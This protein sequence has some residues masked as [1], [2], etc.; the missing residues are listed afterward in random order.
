MKRLALLFWLLASVTTSAQ[1]VIFSEDVITRPTAASRTYM[2]IVGGTPKLIRAGS[3]PIADLTPAYSLTGLRNMSVTPDRVWLN[4]SGK[5]G[6]FVYQP[7]NTTAVDNGGATWVVTSSGKRYRYQPENG[8]ISI[9]RFGADSLGQS[10]SVNAFTA[11]QA[12]GFDVDVPP[13][14]YAMPQSLTLNLSRFSMRGRATLDFTMLSSGTAIHIRGDG[15]GN[16]YRNITNEL[17]GLTLVGPG[18]GTSTK[19]LVFDTPAEGGTSHLL[20]RN[21][22]ICAFGTGVELRQNAYIQNFNF[23]NIYANGIGV[24]VPGGIGWNA[25][26]RI[27]LSQCSLFNNLTGLQASNGEADIYLSMCSLDYNSVQINTTGTLIEL[28]G[29]H[30]EGKNY[31]SAPIVA[32]GYGANIKFIGG[33]ML[34]TENTADPTAI[35]SCSNGA[36]VD[37]YLTDLHN[38]EVSGAYFATGNARHQVTIVRPRFYEVPNIPLFISEYHDMLADGGMEA[39]SIQDGWKVVGTGTQVSA[40]RLQSGDG[41]AEVE[42]TLTTTNPRSGSKSMRW[43]KRYGGGSAAGFWLTTPVTAEA[44]AVRLFYRSDIAGTGFLNYIWTN[45]GNTK[46]EVFGTETLSLTT[47]ASSYTEKRFSLPI[48]RPLWATHLLI[49]LNGD[50]LGPGFLYLDDWQLAPY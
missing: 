43:Q 25:G 39:S 14:L 45:A 6:M 50:S 2:T 32:S 31:S 48:R 38:M 1:N 33:R 3:Q 49:T 44:V 5:E 8:R 18:M 13:G 28:H 24:N 29:C 7:T 34:N 19:G 37:F 17:A 27:S 10:S 15:S 16:P 41:N 9:V 4:E 46:Y 35:V 30:I 20:L 40:T 12:S 47:G 21:M 11:A 42:L 22:A 26:E 36:A 23:V